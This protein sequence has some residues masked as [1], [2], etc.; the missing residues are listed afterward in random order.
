VHPPT[1]GSGESE[2]YDADTGEEHLPF[3]RP[4]RR[5]GIGAPTEEPPRSGGEVDEC[6]ACRAPDDEYIWVSDRW[7]VRATRRPTAIPVALGLETR[8]HL[9]L[10]DLPNLL[11]AELGVMTVRL[12]K[13]IRSL[14]VP[15]R[16][17]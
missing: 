8:P 7:R 17:T 9:D 2:P 14:P 13:A 10:G 1:S 5:R 3:E 15:L 16:S 11:A 6:R 4:L 12:E